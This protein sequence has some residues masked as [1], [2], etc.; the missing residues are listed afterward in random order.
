VPYRRTH[1]IRELLDLAA[2]STVEIGR[3][4][5]ELDV[6]TPFAAEYRYEDVPEG[7]VT[8]D[9]KAALASVQSLLAWVAAT[10]DTA[11]R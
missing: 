4:F 7:P 2:D 10:L 1:D 9:R 6:W 8:I 5:Q 3:E 11:E